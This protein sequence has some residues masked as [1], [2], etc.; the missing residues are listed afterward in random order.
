[1][2]TEAIGG[3][4]TN[5]GEFPATGLPTV[6]GW[7]DMSSSGVGVNEIDPANQISNTLF[8]KFMGYRPK[9][10]WPISNDYIYIGPLEKSTYSVNENKFLKIS[11]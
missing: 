10:Y 9:Y 8:H 11:Q 6:L 5:Y 2:I 3:S 7:P 4:Y 1:M